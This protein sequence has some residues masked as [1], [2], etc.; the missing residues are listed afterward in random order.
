[1]SKLPKAPLLEVIL[2]VKWQV[3][4]PDDLK[5]CQY[6]HGDLYAKFRQRYPYREM[7]VSPE[8][9]MDAYR[10]VPAHR[11][12]V[13]ENGYPLVQVGP[14]ILTVNTNDD[15][16]IWEN[17]ERWCVEAFQSLSELYKFAKS[18]NITLALKYFDF[19][20]FDFKKNDVNKYL[21]D[22]FHIKV[23]QTFLK[24]A[25]NPSSIN[26]G[27]FY[28]TEFGNFSLRIFGGKNTNGQMGLVF[29][30]NI[31]LTRKVPATAE[32]S[33]WLNDAHDYVSESFKAMTKGKMY[34]SFK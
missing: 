6:L 26:L 23:N 21:A 24:G 17:Y 19:F 20:P 11:F 10:Y 25:G 13:K 1:M 8:I 18:E 9:P 34:T 27:F 5:K 2:E 29:D 33:K 14:G 32:F 15:E 4:S 12:R 3:E 22:F 7:L 28:D 16:Y 30:T 31:S